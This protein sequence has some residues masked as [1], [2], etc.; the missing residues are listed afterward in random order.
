MKKLSRKAKRNLVAY[1]F[2]APNFIGF[3]VF[4]LGPVIFAFLLAFHSWDGNN[5]MEFTG[6]SNFIK[7]GSDTR[8]W[9]A[10]KNTI[11]YTACAVPLTMVTALGLALLLNSK[12]K[13]REVFRTIAFFPYVASLVAC[14]AV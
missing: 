12:I 1:S 10:L 5:P 7:M 13:G 6:L 2:I 4:T 8:F 3:S 14:A 11:V 9:A